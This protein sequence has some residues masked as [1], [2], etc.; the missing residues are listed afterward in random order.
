MIRIFITNAGIVYYIWGEQ[1]SYYI[2]W[3]T[4]LHLL[5]PIFITLAVD[6]IT[7]TG[8]YCI[9]WRLLLHLLLI[10]HLLDFITFVVVTRFTFW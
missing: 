5:G 8:V 2:C 7:F 9:C 10:L 4:L 3:G 6:F 1:F